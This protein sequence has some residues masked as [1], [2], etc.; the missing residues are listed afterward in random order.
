MQDLGYSKKLERGMG[1][2]RS[3]ID[4]FFLLKS[5][6]AVK[7]YYEHAAKMPIIDY[8]NHLNPQEIAED[9]VYENMTELWLG[10]DHYKWR[11]IRAMGYPEELVTGRKN[12]TSVDSFIEEEELDYR[13]FLAY[14]D[15]VQSLVG[16]PLYHWTHLE[17]KRYFDIDEA[18]TPDT[19]DYIWE[20]CN[21]LL[22]KG[23]YSVRNLLRKQKAETICT[24]DDPADT[25]EW[26]KKIAAD[27]F[28]ISV[29]PSF[30][31]G[32]VLEIEDDGFV[33]YMS[34]LGEAAGIEITDIE[35]LLA[36]LG[37]RL[38]YFVSVGCRVT[39]HSLEK[40]FFR[41]TTLSAV[42]KI[43]KKR[44]SEESCS[45]TLDEAAAFRGYVLICLGKMYAER[46]MVMQ[47]H[48]GALRNNSER[49]FK[50]LGADS[51]YDSIGD[52]NYIPQLAKLL[53]VM[54]AEDELP[55]TILYYLNPKDA[56]ALSTLAGCFQ[57]NSKGIRGK[58]QLGSAW[59]FNDHKFGIEQQLQILSDTGLLSTF[60][61]MLTDSRSFLS[62]PRHEYFR[63]I[64]CDRLGTLVEN[65]EYPYDMIYLGEMVENICYNN[66][67]DYFDFD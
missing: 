3:I 8:H 17:L 42:D 5:K 1:C 35:T 38:D 16:S 45:I 18:L 40:D 31:P 55:R 2:M 33:S 25:L 13:R 20:K 27:D 58:V 64:L 6:P 34:E 66:A 7:L 26:H 4:E 49:M 67:K 12:V 19:A 43:F 24:T 53:S 54:D 23:D 59:W 56:M 29:R 46:E 57:G 28:E 30:R 62:F 22:K 50:I 15:T 36:A 21:A 47:L 65:G 41:E 48:I 61:G 11:A 52:F 39:D 37:K 10:G 9:K 60:I 63:R 14:A 44:L 32:R 51:G